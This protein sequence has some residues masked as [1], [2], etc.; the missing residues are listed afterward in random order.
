MSSHVHFE[1][2]RFRRK[3]NY[4]KLKRRNI[5]SAN[6]PKETLIGPD[7]KMNQRNLISTFPPTQRDFF[8]LQQ[9]IELNGEFSPRKFSARD[10]HY[11]KFQKRPLTKLLSKP[12]FMEMKNQESDTMAKFVRRNFIKMLPWWMKFM[13][14][15]GNELSISSEI[16]RRWNHSFSDIKINQILTIN[17][18]NLESLIILKSDT[19]KEITKSFV[20]ESGSS[21]RIPITLI[22]LDWACFYLIVFTTHLSFLCLMW[23]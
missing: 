13:G 12:Y 1:E 3:L 10:G 7:I 8:Y 18:G 11:Q 6:A 4:A 19:S 21:S 16:W 5:A 14:F 20:W 22:R 23:P 15:Q 17:E 9:K 2:D